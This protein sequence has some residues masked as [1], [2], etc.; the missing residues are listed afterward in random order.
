MPSQPISNSL[1]I[2]RGIGIRLKE[3]FKNVSQKKMFTNQ[4][5]ATQHPHKEY[6]RD[7]GYSSNHP[8]NSMLVSETSK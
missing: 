3:N 5:F 2:Q 7:R 1:I 8:A 6:H 4:N